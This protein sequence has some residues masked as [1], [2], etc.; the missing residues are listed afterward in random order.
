MKSL[1]DP[2]QAAR[3]PDDLALRAYTSRLLG[4]DHA[5]VMHGG[6][7]TS[8]KLR[9]KGE[10]ILYIKGSGA[11]LAQVAETDF[12][13]VRLG[14]V[15]HLIELDA[16][17]NAQLIDAFHAAQKDPAASRSSIETLLHAVL[18]FQW[19]EHTHADAVLAVAD[20]VHGEAH[21][22][23][24]LGDAALIV[25]YR[26]SG[27]DLAKA[28]HDVFTRHATS[29]T[30][31]IVLMH[32]GI[33]A[34]GNTARESY[35]NMIEL[36]NR[37]EEYLKKQRAWDIPL[38]FEGLAQEYS[39]GDKA[40]CL[41][42]AALRHDI[43]SAAGCPLILSAFTDLFSLDFAHRPDLTSLARRGPATPHH[44]V[45]AKRVPLLGCDVAEYA[46]DYQLY[47]SENA[48]AD[49]RWLPDPAPR[50][51]FDSQW[52]MCAAGVNAHYA[53][54]A[55]EIAQHAMRIQSRAEALDGYLS[56]SPHEVLAA[57]IEYGGFEDKIRRDQPLA[58][59]VMVVADALA[60][61]ED[62]VALMEQGAAVVGLDRDVAVVTMFNQ[63]GF[64]GI[65][66]ESG[67]AQE[68][69]LPRGVRAFGGID[70]LVGGDAVLAEMCR[71]FLALS[72][73]K[74]GK[75]IEP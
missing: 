73:V 69:A 1:L 50:I 68:A 57:E 3:Q 58:G 8:V 5:L 21:I 55:G 64:L 53:Q 41:K 60:C 51:V 17:D 18:P 23:A 66:C 71:P 7:N 70:R 14:Q 43:S 30:I 31:G 28:C 44:A 63:A 24:A 46:R 74:P 65:V 19:V 52:G 35:E 47:I 16:L 15:R 54:V 38:E 45:F 49:A 12:V 9:E 40:S 37:A 4:G 62:V 33:F 22:R 13:A 56:L 2:N 20:T 6:G 42:L 59:Q 27:F 36:V 25:P 75:S 67:D 29:K 61:R 11:D 39:S 48:P 34:F 32:H 26:H 10:D 72:P